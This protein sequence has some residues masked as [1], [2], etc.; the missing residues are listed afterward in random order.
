MSHPPE[1][2][3]HESLFDLPGPRDPR[4]PPTQLLEA[5]EERP[6]ETTGV[7]HLPDSPDAVDFDDVTVPRGEA[8][9]LDESQEDLERYAQAED[10]ARDGEGQP[11]WDEA[12]LVDLRP[13]E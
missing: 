6:Q 10:A 7:R 1:K 8:A 11:T 9:T 3:K 12:T 13:E 5:P 2:K 4:L